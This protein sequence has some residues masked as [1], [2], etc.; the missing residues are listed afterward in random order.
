MKLDQLSTL[1]FP[2]LGELGSSLTVYALPEMSTG[3]N[4]ETAPTLAPVL[5]SAPAQAPESATA[6]GIFPHFLDISASKL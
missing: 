6:L 5:S 1:Y 4:S 2:E 3:A